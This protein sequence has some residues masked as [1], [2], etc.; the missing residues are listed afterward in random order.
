MLKNYGLP[1]TPRCRWHVGTPMVLRDSA[2]PWTGS[3]NNSG[4]RTARQIYRCP[5]VGCLC[6]QTGPAETEVSPAERQRIFQEFYDG[7]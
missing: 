4:R 2:I 1:L 6:C 3:I 7:D 5:V